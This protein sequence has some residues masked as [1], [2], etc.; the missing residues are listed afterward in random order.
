MADSPGGVHRK[1]VHCVCRWKGHPKATMPTVNMEGGRRAATVTLLTKER[2]RTNKGFYT[3]Y[4]APA[5]NHSEF[6]T[7]LTH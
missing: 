2:L 3:K 4:L 7:V 6:A 1:R 5:V